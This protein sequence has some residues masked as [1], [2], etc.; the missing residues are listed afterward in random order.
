MAQGKGSAAQVLIDFETAYGVDP[1]T[2]AAIKMP[3]V[4]PFDLK[5][6]RPLKKSDVLQS[7]PNPAMPYY[8]NRDVKGSA[9]VPVD[10][11]GF[12]YWLK[13]MLGAPDTSQPAAD[14]I[15]NAAAVDKSGGLVGIPI[16]GHAFVPD[17]PITIDGT[18]NYDGDHLVV[19]K[20]TNEIVIAATYI[21]ETFAGTE[22]CRS[23]LFTHVFEPSAELPSMVME[24]GFTNVAKF[25]K[26]NGVK[27]SKLAVDFG[28]DKEL[29]AKLD[30]Q[31]ASE[32]TPAGT[33]YDASP[34]TFALT[35]LQ[36]RQLSFQEHG[37]ALATIKDG[38]F[39][40]ARALDGDSIAANGDTRFD[41][42]ELDYD[43]SGAFKLFFQDTTLFEI[44]K[45][46]TERSFEIKLTTGLY[47]ITILFPEVMYEAGTPTIVKGGAYVDF[48]FQAYYED[49]VEAAAVRV[50]IVNT[51]ASYA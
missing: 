2:P 29:T 8:G 11:I 46:G 9:T 48:K 40:L 50:T 45:A 25:F 21:A 36:N 22:T 33:A 39:S 1:N 18:T 13:A 38:S 30:F 37:G 32:A 23:R 41:L 5:G 24:T 49:S 16:T 4:A 3:I 20:T 27:L 51:H 28:G 14:T 19:S 10:L 34:T 31:G 26:F 15:N 42:P 12:G 17:E 47:S 44:A 35:K 43:F 7:N 6:D